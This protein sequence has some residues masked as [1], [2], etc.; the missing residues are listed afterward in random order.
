M[1]M[2]RTESSGWGWRIAV[3]LLVL[4]VLAAAS[5]A[6]YGGTVRHSQHWIEQVLPNDRFPS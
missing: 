1:R 3:A 4:V 6:L 5:L 2:A